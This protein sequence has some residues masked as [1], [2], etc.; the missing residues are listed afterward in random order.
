VFQ[1]AGVGLVLDIADRA[2]AFAIPG[3]GTYQEPCPERASDQTRHAGPERAGNLVHV[4][5]RIAQPWSGPVVFGRFQGGGG[6]FPV[7]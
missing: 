7:S 2:D 3:P 5:C 1:A 4:I 6:L